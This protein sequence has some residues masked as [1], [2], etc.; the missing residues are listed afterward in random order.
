MAAQQ[1]ELDNKYL[2]QPPSSSCWL[3]TVHVGT[4]RGTLET[5]LDVP[6]YVTKPAPDKAKGHIVLYFPDVWGMS[7]NAKLLMDGFA[8]AGFLTLGM[9]FF[10]GDPISKYRSS[11]GDPPPEGFDQAAWRSK[12]W[13]FATENVPKWFDAVRSKYGS[14][15]TKYACTGYC[16][17]APFVC[18]LLAGDIISAGA[19]AHPTSLKDHH[20]LALK[21]KVDPMLHAQAR[22]GRW[23]SADMLRTTSAILR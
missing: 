22:R 15:T 6:T 9:D 18:D 12:H 20:F 19:F 8:D 2:A 1:S 14:E 16:F 17:G 3:G 7:S 5:V 4:P 10:R 11:M 13:N 21:S 23:S